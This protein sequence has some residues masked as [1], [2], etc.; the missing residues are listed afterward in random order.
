M[1]VLILG[2]TTEASALARL[3]AG[4]A[5]FDA[6][7]SYAGR[8]RAP[9]A[10]PIPWRVGGFGGP[11]G[12]ADYLR[13]EGIEALVDATHPFAQRMSWNAAEAAAITGVPLLA[14]R[15]GPWTVQPGDRWLPVADMAAAAQAIGEAPRRV[16]LTVGQQELAPF[17][18]TAQ[19]IYLIR[20]VDPPAP[21]TLPPQAEVFTA[22]GPFE[23]TAEQALLTD[24]AIEVIVTKNSGGSATAAKLA[25]ARALGLPVIMVD[26]PRV[27][28]VEAVETAEA[29][30]DWL[31]SIRHPGEGRD[32]L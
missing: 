11:A 19:H 16:F 6:T 10:Q 24:H 13:G 22:R 27:P 2:G 17:K 29:A 31:I 21:E 15:R 7:L 26:R 14:L 18:A 30:L 32:P 12:L 28:E 4:D 8:T 1:K 25:A 3:L 9:V 5:R 20:S 23:A